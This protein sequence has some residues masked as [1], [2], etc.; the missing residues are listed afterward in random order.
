MFREKTEGSGRDKL[1]P[2]TNFIDVEGLFEKLD[3]YA[4][5]LIEGKFGARKKVIASVTKNL[6]KLIHPSKTP[7]YLDIKKI[8]FDVFIYI[9]FNLCCI[10]I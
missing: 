9:F 4:D 3:E 7:D 6:P 1:I 10:F 2:I 8:L 5:K